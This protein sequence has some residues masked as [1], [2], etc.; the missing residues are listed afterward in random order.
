MP[1]PYLNG[2]SAI[3]Q[4]TSGGASFVVT[5][6]A[7][8]IDDILIVVAINDGG[9]DITCSTSG[10][11]EIGEYDGT[12]NA[13]WFWKRATSPS[14]T[15]PTIEATT[16]DVF[17][18][19]YTVRGCITTGT[20]YEDAHAT[21]YYQ[22]DVQWASG[23]ATT[24]VQRLAVVFATVDN[25]TAW[26]VAPPPTNWTTY[27]D[28]T[29][30][31]GTDARFTALTRQCPLPVSI[32]LGTVGSFSGSFEYFG[33][34]ILGFIPQ[35]VDRFI[36]VSDT[37]SISESVQVFSNQYYI[38][39]TES[40]TAYDIDGVIALN[41]LPTVVL[42][43][44]DGDTYYTNNPALEFTGASLEHDL[45]Y[46]IQIWNTGVSYVS[47]SGSSFTSGSRSSISMPLTVT[48]GNTLIAGGTLTTQTITGI[49]YAGQSF[50]LVKSDRY[51][52][53][54]GYA[55]LFYLPNAPGGTNTL[56]ATF[57]AAVT[58]GHVVVSEY[59]A[60]VTCG[61]G[62][63]TNIFS[64]DITVEIPSSGS[65]HLIVDVYGVNN[66]T[67]VTMAPTAS[68]Q[69]K[70]IQK[71]NMYGSALS[72]RASDSDAATTMSWNCTN[73]GMAVSGI[74][75]IPYFIYHSS[76]SGYSFI[77]IDNISDTNP[78][79]NG[80]RIRCGLELCSGLLSWKV[81]AQDATTSDWGAWSE[82]KS[83]TVSQVDREVSV[84][85]TASSITDS[86]SPLVY[87][88]ERWVS[89]SDTV[90]T[91][92]DV[93]MDVPFSGTVEISV[94]STASASDSISIDIVPDLLDIQDIVTVSDTAI[95]RLEIFISQVEIAI[96]EDIVFDVW[97]DPDPRRIRIENISDTCSVS[98]STLFNYTPELIYT[99]Y[100]GYDGSDI[101]Y[102]I[103]T[104]LQSKT[105]TTSNNDIYALFM[106]YY[107]FWIYKKVDGG[108]HFT[109]LVCREPSYFFSGYDIDKFEY[110]D[111]EID[112]TD[113]I[114]YVISGRKNEQGWKILGPVYEILDTTDDSFSTLTVVGT[115]ETS[116]WD[117]K[118]RHTNITIDS[119]DKPH[120]TWAHQTITVDPETFLSSVFGYISYRNKVSGSWSTTADLF[121]FTSSG[122]YN[123]ELA[124]IDGNTGGDVFFFV[125]ESWDTEGT[126]Y[127]WGIPSEYDYV[128]RD[129]SG[130]YTLLDTYDRRY[131][132]A[133]LSYMGNPIISSGSSGTLSILAEN[134]DSSLYTLYEE[135]NEASMY[136]VEYPVY[137]G[138]ALANRGN[139]RVA[140]FCA[141]LGGDSYSHYYNINTTYSNWPSQ[142]YKIYTYRSTGS[143]QV[144][145]YP[146]NRHL[147]NTS[148][149]SKIGYLII[150]EDYHTSSGS[151]L[152][153]SNVY[154]GEVDLDN[155]TA[156]NI[157]VSDIATVSDAK[158]VFFST[159]RDIN[160]TESIEAIDS[161]EIS[162]SD[163]PIG[164]C[165]IID[166]ASVT[167]TV[168]VFSDTQHVYT[169]DTCSSLDIVIV[170]IGL[171]ISVLDSV[172]P[173]DYNNI[174]KQGATKRNKHVNSWW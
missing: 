76:G 149:E 25:D 15:N 124:M 100:P 26:S 97:P 6:P 62:G 70:R 5:L 101:N 164:D 169:S 170:A 119:N 166:S 171:I 87:Y 66:A 167:E 48:G 144:L 83:F 58:E 158:I 86:P 104:V 37:A 137:Q 165:Y 117:I 46:E 11:A 103:Y 92:D 88:T 68:G 148:I 120:V 161:L 77:D 16:T 7:H 9:T 89:I 51:G 43:N 112:S 44:R 90:G 152:F 84:S 138:N 106:S 36:S 133:S 74:E 56:T 57:S 93:T 50:T 42:H 30:S 19:A 102:R 172:T 95:V 64:T 61:V 131:S 173:L 12:I 110:F 78:F 81:R 139:T 27:S 162:V 17:A 147:N 65:N 55:P 28:L 114:H 31:T 151:N 41:T 155:L 168:S 59:T 91:S 32:G 22:Y 141:P 146:E 163:A 3:N 123:H 96:G 47:S 113:K 153:Y 14:E 174:S 125:A 29:T 21:G 40:V 69:T 38:N 157:S 99:S 122:S 23:F 45:L 80:A 154:Y 72:D 121:P 150:H 132:A 60:S 10:W 35:D 63:S 20:P 34:C 85:D 135:T 39:V 111:A 134:S 115:Y 140:F 130:N 118:W 13:N 128:K 107:R 129:S 75:L 2:V 94:I 116:G 156:F 160:K 73:T 82:T 71:S 67:I 145:I 33:T 105:I 143:P 49:T 126:P 136:S 4:D 54:G 18:I 98:D 127:G 8:Q 109:E 24:D 53:G 79:T 142:K 52:T 108:T 1:Y 159:D